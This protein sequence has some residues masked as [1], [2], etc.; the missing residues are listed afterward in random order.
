MFD[1]KIKS[2][3][4]LTVLICMLFSLGCAEVPN[5]SDPVVPSDSDSI[6]FDTE[7]DVLT[8]TSD[9]SSDTKEPSGP[10]ADTS[11][12]SVEADPPQK[13][14][15]KKVSFLCAG[16]NIVYNGQ[17]KEA[18]AYATDDPSYEY[19]FSYMYT[20]IADIIA[21]YDVSFVNQETVMAGKSFGYSAYPEFNTPQDLGRNLAE[22]GFDVINIASNHMLD[23]RE[24]GLRNTINFLRQQDVLMVGGYDN[25]DDFYDIRI[26]ERNGVKIAVVGFTYG[27]NGGNEANSLMIPYIYQKNYYRYGAN[28]QLVDSEKIT[29]WIKKAK[30]EADVVVVSMHWGEEYTQKPSSEQ[31]RLAKIICDNGADII[32][33]HHTHTLQPIEWIKSDNGNKTLCLY[34]LGNLVSQTDEV[35]SLAGGLA[36]FDIIFNE[37][38]GV[39]IEN[40]SFIPLVTDYRNSFKNTKIYLL[41]N[42]TEQLC[43]THGIVVRF[44]KLV[45]MKILA[46]YVKNVIKKEYL[47]DSYLEFYE[48][49]I[50][51]SSE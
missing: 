8:D 6:A 13:P 28:E 14:A 35:I 11:D 51:P 25:E 36:T 30:E 21:S 12:S 41:E 23:M 32:I 44:E 47:P 48:N 7:E 22:I 37:V 46:Y 20:D 18:K 38:D 15:D 9:V 40:I 17:I 29:R 39:R 3:I 4:S 31:K 34:S 33:G 10:S 16:D 26:I 43:Q 19:D 27:T 49:L 1:K 2:I 24:Q 45:S 5:R 42:Y 50:S